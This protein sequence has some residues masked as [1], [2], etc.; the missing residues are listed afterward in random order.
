MSKI[1]NVEEL[2]IEFYEIVQKHNYQL[3]YFDQNAAYSFYI[4]LLSDKSLTKNQAGYILKLLN[5]YKNYLETEGYNLH[6]L[7]QS[8]PWKKDFR[9]IDNGKKI[10]I[11]QDADGVLWLCLQFPFSLKTTFDN[12]FSDIVGNHWDHDKKLR[13]IPLY[14]VNF[15]KIEQF[16]EKHDFEMDISFLDY[17]DQIDD[18]WQNKEFYEPHSVIVDQTVVIKNANDESQEYWKTQYTG[19]VGNDLLTAREMGYFL[20]KDRPENIV[21]KIAVSNKNLFWLKDIKEFFGLYKSVDSKVCV[22]L[23]R[24]SDYFDW[25]KKFVNTA[26]LQGINRT[27]IKVCFREDG[28]PNSPV[29]QWIRDNSVGGKISDGRIFI[30][31]NSPAKWLYKDLDS[32]KIITTNGLFPFTSKTLQSLLSHHSCVINISEAKPSKQREIEIEEL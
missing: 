31:L 23:D 22:I 7:L 28:K 30:F 6:S 13:K 27:E 11:E 2:F 21:E 29:N 15:L 20:K 5:K 1:K 16:V 3:P 4:N 18:I 8:L 10:S 9:V 24:S 32:F 14:S 25:L 26:D 12:E 19:K 17:K